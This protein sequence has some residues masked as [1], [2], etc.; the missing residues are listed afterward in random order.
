MKRLDGASLFLVFAVCL[1]AGGL[2]YLVFSGPK[3]PQDP[4]TLY[5]AEAPVGAAQSPLQADRAFGYLQQVCDLGPR[6]SGSVGMQRQQE[7]L[8][9][10][11]QQLGGQVERQAFRVHH[12]LTGK[13]VRW[14][15]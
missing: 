7:L 2:G 9:K 3:T 11:F 10:H 5:T 8:E 15:I 12:P 13:A 6:F 14:S 4:T 1:A